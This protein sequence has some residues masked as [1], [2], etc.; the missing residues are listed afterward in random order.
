MSPPPV[1]T[2]LPGPFVLSS[3]L[4]HQLRELRGREVG[5][6]FAFADELEFGEG[7]PPLVLAHVVN[8]IDPVPARS[9]AEVPGVQ[10][11]KSRGIVVARPFLNEPQPEF[12]SCGHLL[13]CD[14]GLGRA[15]GAAII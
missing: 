3:R 13:G 2:P 12:H 10:P 7:L 1:A 9:R 5:E 8:E 4:A 11:K 14:D 6:T 15:A